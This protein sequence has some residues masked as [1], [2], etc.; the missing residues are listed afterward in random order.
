[1]TRPRPP[2]ACR[3]CA[4]ELQST[5]TGSVQTARA[6]LHA[7]WVGQEDLVGAGDGSVPVPRHLPCDTRSARKVMPRGQSPTGR[8]NGWNRVLKARR[9]F[10]QQLPLHKPRPL[11]IHH[12]PSLLPS[13][14]PPRRIQRLR[15]HRARSAQFMASSIYNHKHL[16]PAGA[17]TQAPPG[18][19]R[20]GLNDWLDNIRNEFDALA[21]EITLVRSQ[22]DDFENKLTGQVNELNIIRQTLYQLEDEHRKIR[23]HF[24][25]E[26]R[27]TQ[28]SFADYKARVEGP[29]REGIASLGRGDRDRDRERERERDRERD[30]DRDRDRDSRI[31]REPSRD[32]MSLAGPQRGDLRD[33]IPAGRSA[34][35]PGVAPDGPIGTMAHATPVGLGVG[36]GVGGGYVDPFYGRV[37]RDRDREREIERERMGERAMRDG[38]ADRERLDRDR[39]RDRD[40]RGERD[41]GD[42]KRI[43]T[44]RGKIDRQDPFSPSLQALPQHATPHQSHP[45][46]SIGSSGPPPQGASTGPS[47]PAGSGPAANSSHP[48]SKLPLTPY[49]ATGPGQSGQPTTPSSNVPPPSVLGTGTANNVA[50]AS[51]AATLPPPS[52]ISLPPPPS[53][54]PP[55][56]SSSAAR[57]ASHPPPSAGGNSSAGRPLSPTSVDVTMTDSYT[58]GAGGVDFSDIHSVPPEFK[59]EGSD[60]FAV[61]NSQAGKDGK[62]KALDVSLV[63]TLLHESVVCCVRF[64]ANGRFLATGCNRTAQI[65]DTKTGQKT[66]VLIDEDASKTG[67]LYIRSVC[68][69]PD[70]KY[71]ATGAEDK[72]IRI[73]DIAEKRIRMVF[74]GHQ[75]EIYSLDFSRDGRLIVSG[76]GDKTAR[77]WSM[78]DPNH[79]CKI[80]SI[81]E[82]DS[83]DAGVT[84][85][86]I[87]PDGNLV[88]AGSL[89]TIV[90]IWDVHSGDLIE[91][92]KGH[93]DSV[94]SVAFT[95]DGR[96][97]VS[98]SLD[99]TL[100]YW[101]VQPLLTRSRNGSV[102]KN[103]GPSS[104]P[105]KEGSVA[106][107]TSQ[108]LMNF[109]GH[110]DYVLSVAVS[111][112]GQW[113]VSGSKDRGVQF[114]DAKSAVVQC[115]LQGHK[116]SVISIDLSPVGSLLATGSGDWQARIWS[117]N[118]L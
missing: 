1:M 91:R 69:S 25:E 71:L 21:S 17:A 82:P 40:M 70:G 103:G 6:S 32:P 64:S 15:R 86:C 20:L 48:A 92:L 72:Q 111:H 88:A 101:D 66:C 34:G 53:S 102:S 74:D 67:D 35:H 97:L 117:Y 108:C 19:P 114:W 62:K 54:L 59:K 37:E 3:L 89:D 11:S 43:K 112:D 110:K 36:P 51:G 7:D 73:W 2:A 115:M 13:S 76:S 80:L 5:S 81:D 93:R 84:S 16:Q 106:D 42:L 58:S 23:V 24:E 45:S 96:G 87:S 38:R 47:G 116:N 98:G 83:V 56:P 50:G 9:L 100:K 26:L 79:S 90:R 75:Q 28:Q 55:Q 22:R 104:G 52:S 44:E 12:L 68:F 118:A 29:T 10:A 4:K 113:V 107:K 49:S 63:H 105:G 46:I 41:R 39:E 31:D 94:Y 27:K 99:K 30:R 78:T 61:F 33:V 18:Q 8:R 14:S 57:Q 95:P 65:Y 60:W 85:V 77:V 109:T